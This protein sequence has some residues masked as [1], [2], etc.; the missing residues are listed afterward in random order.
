MIAHQGETGALHMMADNDVDDETGKTHQ[1]NRHEDRLDA[2]PP[3]VPGLGSLPALLLSG[4][5]G[6][7]T[8]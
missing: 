1:E 2:V 5:N 7:V 4:R 3:L 6:L 8:L